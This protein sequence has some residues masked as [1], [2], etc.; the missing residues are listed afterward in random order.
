MDKKSTHLNKKLHKK[1]REKD[2]PG[3]SAVDFVRQYARS[4]RQLPLTAVGLRSV[5]LN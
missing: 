2:L 5:V 1:G 3:S 4:C